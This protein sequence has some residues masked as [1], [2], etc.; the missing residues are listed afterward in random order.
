MLGEA[1]SAI[2]CQGLADE[3]LDSSNCLIWMLSL[4]SVVDLGAICFPD[5]IVFVS[6]VLD[7]RIR[8]RYITCRKN[9]Y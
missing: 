5:K 9:Q 2:M 1:P 3:H 7:Q 8:R 6:A 4:G